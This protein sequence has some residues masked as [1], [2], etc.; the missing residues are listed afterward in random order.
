MTSLFR[1]L[2]HERKPAASTALKGRII[3]I[4][5]RDY[6]T[7]PLPRG[8]FSSIAREAGCSIPYVTRVV[9]AFRGEA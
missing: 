4:L 1:F 2:R 3:D 8:A 7:L 9:R 6:G 5:Q